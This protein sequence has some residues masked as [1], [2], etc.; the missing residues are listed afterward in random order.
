MNCNDVTCFDSFRAANIQRKIK[1][2]IGNKSMMTNIFR[3]QAHNSIMCRYVCISFTDFMLI[4][5]TLLGYTNLF[6]P[7]KYEKNAKV[8]KYFQ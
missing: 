8:K 7:K 5:M 2:S 1:K 6:S 3:V 4:D